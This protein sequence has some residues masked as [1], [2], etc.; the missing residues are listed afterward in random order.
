MYEYMRR[1]APYGLLYCVVK[2]EES[3]ESEFP[4]PYDMAVGNRKQSFPRVAA[5]YYLPESQVTPYVKQ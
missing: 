2:T 4:P 1:G 3:E 5:E